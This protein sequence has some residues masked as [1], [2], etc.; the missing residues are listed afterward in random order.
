M[1]ERNN[2][3][4]KSINVAFMSIV[5]IG[6]RQDYQ[7]CFGFKI[8]SNIT[9]IKMMKEERNFSDDDDEDG[10]YDDDTALSIAANY[11]PSTCSHI[12][13]NIQCQGM[14]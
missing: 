12:Y 2:I 3:I 11:Q 9:D 10:I 5:F 14:N 4:L 1:R 6:G 13:I 8:L 7:D